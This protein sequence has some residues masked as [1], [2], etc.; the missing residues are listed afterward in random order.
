MSDDCDVAIVVVTYN[1][2]EL[3]PAL[4]ASLGPAAG[5]VPTQLIFVDNG[6]TDGTVEHLRSLEP[7]PLVVDMGRNAGY[8]AGV[9]LVLNP[10]VRLGAQC[11]PALLSVLNTPGTGIVVPRLTDDRGELTWSLR[12]RPSILRAFGDALLGA[13]RAAKYPVFGDLISDSRAYQQPTTCDWAEGSVQLIGADCWE[14]CGVWDESFFLYSE[15]TEYHLRVGDAGYAVRFAPDAHAVHLGGESRT[16]PALWSLLISN[17]ARLYRR[18][19]GFLPFTAYWL[20]LVLREASRTVLGNRT[21][22]AALVTLLM[23]SGRY[24][25]RKYGFPVGV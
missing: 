23:P 15:E 19:S 14:R 8:A 4:L 24:L 6:S 13:R 18:R 21:S 5:P 10:D 25:R 1:S 11:I 7:A 20:A 16:S 17:K 22:R 2:R 3:L 9:I 12:R